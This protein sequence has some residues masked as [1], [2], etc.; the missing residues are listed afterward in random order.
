M[1]FF[2]G[3]EVGI[4]PNAAAFEFIHFHVLRATAVPTWPYS[5]EAGGI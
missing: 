4:F 3:S 5:E 2:S 1:N